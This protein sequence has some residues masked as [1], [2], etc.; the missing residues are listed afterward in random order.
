MGGR[1]Y[2]P[3]TPPN[4]RQLGNRLV[5]VVA[6]IFSVTLVVYFEGGLEDSLTGEHPGFLDCLYFTMVT[7]TT[8]G[9][10]D[11]VPV[12]TMSRL[13]D[14]LLLTPIRFIIIFTIFGTAYEIALKRFR[15]DYRMHRITSKLA[16]HTVICGFGPTSEAAVHEL[17]L[18]GTAPDQ[19]VVL[20]TNE[21][22]LKEAAAIG[23]VAIAG[24]A[25]QEQ[26]LKSA[27]IARAAHVLI[28]PGRDDTA[29]LMALTVRDMNP[30]AQVIVLCE[31]DENARLIK[32]SGAHVIINPATAGGTLM[33]AATRQR[34]LVDTM[35]DILSVGGAMSIK[36]R[37]ARED[38]VGKPPQQLAGMAVLRV[39]REGK[40]FDIAA[41]PTI[42]AGDVLVYVAAPGGG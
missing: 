25:T 19:I 24:D 33:A 8:V 37:M 20:A 6:L 29:V 30:A 9:Y 31:Q 28:A 36:E 17:M 15:E 2:T 7:I 22:S 23:V 42:E 38:E 16:G 27:A 4:L 32:R 35:Q 3:I 14:A 1:L 21:E 26:V 18:Q 41:L 5:L 10:G 40:H 13:V 12:Y 11:I 39:Y 34:H